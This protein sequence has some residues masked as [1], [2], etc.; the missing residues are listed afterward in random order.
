MQ[1]LLTNISRRSKQAGGNLVR[2][3][4]SVAGILLVCAFAAGVV[5]TLNKSPGAKAGASEARVSNAEPPVPAIRQGGSANGTL[6]AETIA[7][8]PWGFEPDEI[9]RPQGR[10]VLRVDNRSG[11]DEVSLRLDNEAG[12]SLRAAAVPRS[13]LDWRDLVELPPGTYSL[14]EADHPGWVC[15]IIITP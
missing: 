9:T 2:P 15:R 7:I 10:F 14:K 5:A 6:Q 13:K 4:R 12:N 1:K 11:L 8:R 3:P